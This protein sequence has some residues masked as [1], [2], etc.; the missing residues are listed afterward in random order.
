[1][2]SRDTFNQSLFQYNNCSICESIGLLRTWWKL[3]NFIQKN[4]ILIVIMTF[5]NLLITF[6]FQSQFSFAKSDDT[7]LK[8]S[9]TFFLISS[10]MTFKSLA[11]LSTRC[12]FSI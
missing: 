12:S 11:K 6:S 4:V 10:D 1:M 2:G 9:I 7:L 8:Y 5:F 3:I